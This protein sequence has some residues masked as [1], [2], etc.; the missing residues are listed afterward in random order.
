MS[1]A[2]GRRKKHEEHEEHENHERWLVTYADMLT[3]LMVLFIVMFAMS[4]VDEKK[5]NALKNGLSEGFGASSSFMK[6]SDSILE[7]HLTDDATNPQLDATQ[8]FQQLSPKNQAI[9][10]Q[11]VETEQR[12]TAYAAATSEARKLRDA[13]KKIMAALKQKGLANDVSTTI[14]DR[15]LVVSLVSRHVTFQPNIA[16]LSPRGRQVVD[17]I[18]PVLRDLPNDLRVDGH[19][20]QAPGRPKY[21]ATDWDLSAARA[22]EVLRRL[23][24][25]TGIPGR[26]MSLEAF[27]HERPLLDPKTPGSQAVNKR[28]DIVVLPAVGAGASALLDEAADAVDDGHRRIPETPTPDTHATTDTTTDTT[29][30]EHADEAATADHGLEGEH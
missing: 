18:A 13:Q 21:Y 4:Q 29:T 15:G 3:L 16:T 11:A 9:V 26:R 7:G 2:H 22:V 8:I 30:D 19:T 6:G 17:T 27:G 5:Y 23:N 28:V 24:E 14:D 1:A 10:T 12:R 25:H 20:N